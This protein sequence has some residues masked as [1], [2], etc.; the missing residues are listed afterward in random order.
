MIISK[1]YG[2]LGNQ[3]FQYAFA[4]NL[5]LKYG[6]ELKFDI[7]ALIKESGN[8]KYIGGDIE[9]EALDVNLSKATENEINLF[10]RS[11][12]GKLVDLVLLFFHISGKYSYVKEPHFHFFKSALSS[13]VN[14]Y[15][16]GYWQSEKYFKGIRKHLLQEFKPKHTLSFKTIELE[17][18]I[19]NSKSI[20]IHV[21]RGDYLSNTDIYCICDETYYMNSIEFICKKIDNPT[22]YI[23]SDD[24]NWFKNNI[25]TDYKTVYVSHNIGRNSYEDIYLM[26]LCQHQIIA[27]S[28][29]SWWGA[30]LNLNPNKIVIAP[31]CWFK[32]KSKN[33]KDLIPEEWIQL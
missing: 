33:T 31:K 23:F 9:L 7:T 29:F 13:P 19:K 16:D 32:I 25:K 12:F 10:M 4:R 1:L 8:S 6:V 20:S 28:S 21:R 18:E 15:L 3:M 27:N 22:L 17:K 11:K 5:A 14:S 26:S 2:G 24:P 30:W